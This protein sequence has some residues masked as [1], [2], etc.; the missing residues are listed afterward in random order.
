MEKNK[1]T[2]TSTSKKK[3]S[4]SISLNSILIWLVLI[5]IVV[6]IIIDVTKLNK[7]DDVPVGTIIAFPSNSTPK[8]YLP[9]DGSDIPG[10]YSALIKF[11]GGKTKTPDLRKMFIRGWTEDKSI[12]GTADA[13]TSAKNL[14]IEDHTHGML[15]FTGPGGSGQPGGGDIF[16]ASQATYSTATGVRHVA[17]PNDATKP[18]IESTPLTISGDE[19]TAPQHIFIPFYIKC[20]S[21][22]STN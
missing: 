14:S 2:P 19:E 7:G 18:A 5:G 16:Y 10:K 11:L 4:F 9:C 8:G 1:S 12:L 21:R 6:Y 15:S 17:K 3:E 13:T 20:G 22:A